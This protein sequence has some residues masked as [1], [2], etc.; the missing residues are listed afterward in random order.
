MKNEK[1]PEKANNK[2]DGGKVKLRHAVLTGLPPLLIG[3]SVSSTWLI[4][5]GRWQEA[6]AL[7]LRLG[8][9]AG[10][11]FAGI[12]AVGGFCALVKRFPVWGFSWLGADVVGFLLIMKS[13]AE[14]NELLK[15]RE[16]HTGLL[17]LTAIFAAVVFIAAVQRGWQMAGL[18]SIGMSTTMALVN[19]HMMAIPPFNRVDL[20]ILGLIFGLVFFILTFAYYRSKNTVQLLILS[21]IA[22]FNLVILW[23]ANSVWSG[24]L[25]AMGKASPFLPMAVIMLLMLLAGPIAGLFHKPVERVLMHCTQK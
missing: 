20:A 19:I 13:I 22:S 4:I 16:V 7:E 5:S 2:T 23:L 9:A 25:S 14:E 1:E 10:I 21:I 3:S 17:G 24:Y 6:T 12:V 15:S 11:I 18:V 8:L